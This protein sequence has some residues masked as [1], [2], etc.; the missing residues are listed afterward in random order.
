[1]YANLKAEMARRNIE[2]PVLMRITGKSRAA[3][4]NYLNGR[5]SFSVTEAIQIRDELFPGLTIDYLF[6]REK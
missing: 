2:I 1:M 5:G 6:S 4:S 3:V